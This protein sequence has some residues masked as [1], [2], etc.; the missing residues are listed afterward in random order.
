MPDTHCAKLQRRPAF[1]TN[2]CAMI[3]R[4]RGHRVDLLFLKWVA[5]RCTPMMGPN[6]S[7]LSRR[8]FLFLIVLLGAPIAARCNAL[9]DSAR[10]LARKIATALSA[11]NAVSMEMRNLSSLT[12]EE[13]AGVEEV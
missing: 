4:S 3:S 6:R 13:F 2:A 7:R 8:T 12:P 1:L 5:G 10:E 9:E 11:K